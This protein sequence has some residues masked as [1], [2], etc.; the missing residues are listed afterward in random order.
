MGKISSESDLSLV[1]TESTGE[2][3]AVSTIISQC[4]GTAFHHRAGASEIAIKGPGGSMIDGESIGA[5]IHVSYHNA[6][7]L[8]PSGKRSDGFV[9]RDLQGAGLIVGEGDGGGIA[10]TVTTTDDQGSGL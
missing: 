4:G 1:D 6:G 3:A 10:D 9:G 7:I 5:D 8:L 2:G